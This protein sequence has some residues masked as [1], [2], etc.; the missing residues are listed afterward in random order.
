MTKLKLINLVNFDKPVN[1]TGVNIQNNNDFLCNFNEIIRIPPNSEVCLLHGE[2]NNTKIDPSGNVTTPNELVYINIPTLP[3]KTY[4][5][6]FGKGKCNQI[7]GYCISNL[8]ENLN[9]D[10]Y[11]SLNNEEEIV[12]TQLRVQILDTDYDLKVFG[13]VANPTQKFRQSI[14]LGVRSCS[15]NK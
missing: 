2:I 1:G 12:L 4:T 7:V 5:G 10:M 11:V 8:E 3:I 14:L 13:G 9:N 15:C 6:T